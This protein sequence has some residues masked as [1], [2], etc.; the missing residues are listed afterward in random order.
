M[1]TV[2][3]LNF[4]AAGGDGFGQN[5]DDHQSGPGPVGQWLPLPLPPVPKLAALN[6]E[7]HAVARAG[8]G[9][10]AKLASRHADL[11]KHTMREVGLN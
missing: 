10:T 4:A 7:G 6:C 9:W 1:G 11:T 5:I 3:E 2:S 8:E